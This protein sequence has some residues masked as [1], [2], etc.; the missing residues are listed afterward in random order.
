MRFHHSISTIIL[1]LLPLREYIFIIF[2][3]FFL[4]FR[5]K[6]FPTKAI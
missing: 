6:P 2:Y 3:R 5:K 1:Y 4:D